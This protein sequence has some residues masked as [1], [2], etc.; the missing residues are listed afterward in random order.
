MEG[1]KDAPRAGK[2]KLYV[3]LREKVLK[4]LE[5]PP[6]KGQAAWD[7]LRLAETVGAKKSSVYALLQKD[8]VQLQRKRSWCVSTDSN[9][10]AKAAD[11]IG[12][13]LHPPARALV[14]SVDEKPSIQAL[15]RTTGYV[16]TSSGKIV[17]GLK[18]TYRR[19]GTLNL[20][21]ALNVATGKRAKRRRKQRPGST[22][23]PSWTR[24]SKTRPPIK[25][26]TSSS[27]TMPP[28]RKTTS[29]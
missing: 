3:G 2:P 9:F 28:T 27:T 26:F 17:R 22:S 20:F 21:A 18:S 11:I 13:Y 16:R 29:G 23:R 6:P 12:L 8:G 19:N 5:M 4:T 24:L 7:G 10:A 15:S 25:K 1:L 14:L